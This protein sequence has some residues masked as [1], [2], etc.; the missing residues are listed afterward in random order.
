VKG[1]K[2]PYKRDI[3]ERS[4]GVLSV[5]RSSEGV[6]SPQCG[7][8]GSMPIEELSNFTCKSVHFGDFMAS[9]DC[10]IL[11][12]YSRPSIFNGGDRPFASPSVLPTTVFIARRRTTYEMSFSL[13]LK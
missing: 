1:P 6:R 8:S 9:F 2:A 12:G 13:L 4:A 5:G 11:A 3:E 10:V 7:V